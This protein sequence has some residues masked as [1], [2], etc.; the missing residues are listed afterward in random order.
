MCHLPDWIS[1][2]MLIYINLLSRPQPADVTNK[3]VKSYAVNNRECLKCGIEKVGLKN[4][5]IIDND[6]TGKNIN[7]F[8]FLLTTKCKS[9]V[10]T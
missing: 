4:S 6:E 5:T 7:T 9:G 3:H 1:G 8:L 10:F 2:E